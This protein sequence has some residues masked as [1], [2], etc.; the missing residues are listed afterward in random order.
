MQH[1]SWSWLLALVVAALAG[2]AAAAPAARESAG[3]LSVT[4]SY[5]GKGEVDAKHDI[6]VFLFDTPNIG[7]GSLPIAT[8]AVNKNGAAAKFADLSV[9]PVYVGVAYDETG[10]YDGFSGPPPPGTPVA[11]YSTDGKGTPAPVDVSGT[12]QITM[13]FTDSQRT[14]G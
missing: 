14:G 5:K 2:V 9:S 1:G 7:A 3:E 12:A 13:T 6:F 10:D 11:I 4:V 8:R